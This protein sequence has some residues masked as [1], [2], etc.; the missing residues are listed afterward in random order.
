MSTSVVLWKTWKACLFACSTER[1]LRSRNTSRGIDQRPIVGHTI[2][3][4]QTDIVL[5]E[6]SLPVQEV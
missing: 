6:F 2:E 3:S 1:V 5:V 4:V